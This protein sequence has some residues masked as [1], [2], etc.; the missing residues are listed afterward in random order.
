MWVKGDMIYTVGFH[1][2][3]LVRTERDHTGRRKYLTRRIPDEELKRIRHCVLVGLGWLDD[4]LID[5]MSGTTICKAP[6]L[7]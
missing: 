7:P 3:D 2:L 4:A 5:K 1:R 6:A